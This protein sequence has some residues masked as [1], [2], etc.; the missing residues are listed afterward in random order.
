MILGYWGLVESD[1]QEIYSTD[2]SEVLD[3]KTW[4]WVQVR[5]GGLFSSENSRLRRTLVP[6]EKPETKPQARR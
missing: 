6:D 1:F 2:L 3:H 4:R 5:I